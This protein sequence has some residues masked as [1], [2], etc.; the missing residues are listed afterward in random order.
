VDDV[1]KAPELVAE[2]IGHF[3]AKVRNL[4]VKYGVKFGVKSG[5]N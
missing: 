3:M 2:L 4:S 5:V 1:P